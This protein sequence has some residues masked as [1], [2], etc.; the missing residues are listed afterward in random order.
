MIAVGRGDDVCSV[1]WPDLTEDEW[2]ARVLAILRCL[3]R[4]PGQVEKSIALPNP[5][6]ELYISRLTHCG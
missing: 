2:E 5:S 3:T 4:E 6:T 1:Q